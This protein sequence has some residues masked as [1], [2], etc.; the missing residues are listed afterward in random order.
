MALTSADVTGHGQRQLR[1]KSGEL[2]LPRSSLSSP[3]DAQD[4]DG[5][6]KGGA[7]PRW[8]PERNPHGDA[9][10]NSGGRTRTRVPEGNREGKRAQKEE[11][12]TTVVVDKILT[13]M[14]R[15]WRRIRARR[16]AAAFGASVAFFSSSGSQH[17]RLAPARK[18]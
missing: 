10:V 8:S 2:R 4:G 14:K 16:P 1:P 6:R 5:P 7:A 12:L 9:A 15:R 18:G 13:A 3:T 11:Q 17:Q